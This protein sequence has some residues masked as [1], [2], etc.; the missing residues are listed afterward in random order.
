MG[1]W[2]ADR[3]QPQLCAVVPAAERRALKLDSPPYMAQLAA[4]S[5]LQRALDDCHLLSGRR[6]IF[7]CGESHERLR[8]QEACGGAYRGGARQTRGAIHV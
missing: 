2:P 4:C 7:G 5:R 3:G 6:Y 1:R 8:R